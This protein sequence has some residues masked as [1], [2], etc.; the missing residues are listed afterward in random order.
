MNEINTLH[1]KISG[2]NKEINK[3]GIIYVPLFEKLSMELEFMSGKVSSILAPANSGKT[4]LFKILAGLDTEFSGNIELKINKK[5]TA[6]IKKIYIP[7]KPSSFPW[8]NVTENC[9]LALSAQNQSKE[10]KEKLIHSAIELTG[11]KGYE[12]HYPQNVSLGF[13]FRISLAR[14]LAIQP[15]VVFIDDSFSDMENKTKEEVI[16]LVKKIAEIEKTVFVFST[17]RVSDAAAISEEVVLFGNSNFNLIER[18]DLTGKS[19]EQRINY[20]TGKISS[21]NLNEFAL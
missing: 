7:Q 10:V 13:R 3:N 21:S 12:S 18:I 8:L 4:T 11:L 6:E 9:T 17:N 14:A 1:I 16:K 2:I 15:G 5:N 19:T 20:I